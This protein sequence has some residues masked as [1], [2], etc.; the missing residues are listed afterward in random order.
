MQKTHALT[1]FGNSV[2][3][4]YEKPVVCG[5]HNNKVPDVGCFVYSAKSWKPY[6]NLFTGGLF[7]G[8]VMFPHQWEKIRMLA[9][10]SNGTQ[11][12]SNGAWTQFWAQPPQL[13]DG[14][15]LVFIDNNRLMMIGGQDSK[16]TYILDVSNE[17]N[18]WSQFCH[19]LFLGNCT[20]K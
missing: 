7:S 10:G 8:A 19:T 5:G 6:Y 2:L 18:K 16:K 17:A 3:S 15:C 12:L 14:V 11:K 20:E 4:Y 1:G 9:A 13:L